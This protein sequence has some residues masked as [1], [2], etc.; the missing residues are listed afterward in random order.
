MA[1]AQTPQA[2]S[3]APFDPGIA[4]SVM[5]GAD[6]ASKERTAMADI[7]GRDRTAATQAGAQVQTAQIGANAEMAMN[8][9]RVA[10]QRSAQDAQAANELRMK[11]MDAEIIRSSKRDQQRFEADMQSQLLNNQNVSEEIKWDRLLELSRNTMAYD[12]KKGVVGMVMKLKMMKEIMKT[13][14]GQQAMMEATDRELELGEERELVRM[15]LADMTGRALEPDSPVM[16][17][18]R[19]VQEI[20]TKSQLSGG[21]YGGP[22]GIQAVLMR[23]LTNSGITGLEGRDLLGNGEGISLTLAKKIE[24]GELTT[25]ELHNLITIVDAASDKM[26]GERKDPF[27]KALKNTFGEILTGITRAR[28]NGSDMVKSSLSTANMWAAGMTPPQRMSDWVKKKGSFDVD[29]MLQMYMQLVEGL[30]MTYTGE[31][32]MGL[33]QVQQTFGRDMRKGIDL[34]NNPT[35]PVRTERR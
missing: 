23:I 33:R 34:M 18:G 4:Q 8:A 32:G 35:Q 28:L 24:S 21:Q 27:E 1:R 22:T 29:G 17:E 15:S 13:A 20:V 19:T 12:S 6:I 25:D 5:T 14:E 30:N 16:K 11:Q 2:V 9:Q 3:S 7:A 31:T 26:K 10:A